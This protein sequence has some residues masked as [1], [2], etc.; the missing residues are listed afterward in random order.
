M[1]SLDSQLYIAAREGRA[2]EVRTLV[3]AGANPNSLHE[4]AEDHGAFLHR[5]TPLM[6]AAGSPRS[7]VDTVKVL[8]EAGADPFAVGSGELTALWFAAGGGTGYAL[9]PKNTQDMS[10]DHPY[11][12]WGGGDVERLRVL[13]DAGLPAD[14]TADNG[15]SAFS[16]ACSLGDFARAKLLVERGA[17]VWPSKTPGITSEDSFLKSLPDDLR[18]KFMPDPTG[19]SSLSIPL[20]QAAEAGDLELV[21]FIL[22]Q[23]FPVDF[24]CDG[25]N[26]LNH[27]GSVEVAEHFLALGLKLKEGNF[28]FDSVDDLFD[29][30][31]NEVAMAVLNQIPD[32]ATRK[33]QIQQK[34][35]MCCGVRMNPNAVRLLLAA[36]AEANLP[37]KD[38]G[39]PLHY[40]CWQ[41]DGNGGR[42]N[43]VAEEVVRILLEAGADPNMTARGSKPLHEAVYGDWGSPTSVR[44][45]LEFGAEVDALDERGHTPLMLAASRG[46]LEC[47]KLLLAAGAAPKPALRSAKEHLKI[48][49][50][51]ASEPLKKVAKFLN[52]FSLGGDPEEHRRHQLETLKIAE[53]CFRLIEEACK[54]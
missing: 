40:A 2:D 24:V 14:E 18:E 36:G 25:E 49:R 9:T 45:L 46:E 21:K 48:W 39:S 27:A 41:G 42:E 26:A 54:S 15:R 35:L 37:D 8:L 6:A 19:Y 30:G 29:D 52:K 44:V 13:L 23:G 4:G 53:E 20:F 38:Y 51:L 28:G 10:A 1:S 22:D 16:E 3:T 17:S 7:N 31:R 5:V 11:W 33:A 12:N 47:I 32:P 43:E 34:L 50:S